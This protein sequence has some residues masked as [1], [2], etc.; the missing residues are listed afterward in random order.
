M[1]S[2][3]FLSLTP[4]IL[5]RAAVWVAGFSPRVGVLDYGVIGVHA[6]PV[7]IH[8]DEHMPSSLI[9]SSSY[10]GF[11]PQPLLLGDSTYQ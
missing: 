9:Y 2:I 6:F 8:Y 10:S 11:D 7:A 3:S 5:S 4:H 1:I